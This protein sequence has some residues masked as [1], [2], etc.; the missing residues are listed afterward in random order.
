MC[1]I[2]TAKSH[3][4]D[5]AFKAV[6]PL[7]LKAALIPSVSRCSV[8]EVSSMPVFFPE[9]DRRI[10]L[11]CRYSYDLVCT[12]WCMDLPTVY[13]IFGLNHVSQSSMR[14]TAVVFQPQLKQ[15]TVQNDKT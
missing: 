11:Y 10:T 13:H 3:I 14:R 6:G 8:D 7:S 12:Y 2:P 9:D 1:S 5:F 4:L 15:Q